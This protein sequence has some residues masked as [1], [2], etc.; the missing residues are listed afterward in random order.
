MRR[1]ILLI[2][3][4]AILAS[5]CGNQ[6]T[7]KKPVSF[8]YLHAEFQFG[9]TESLFGIE[10]AESE[11]LELLQ[12]L[13]HYLRGPVSETLR[14]PFPDKVQILS[15][16]MHDDVMQLIMNDRY[17]T[18]SG[19]SLSVANVCLFKTCASLTGIHELQIRTATLLI[20]GMDV[21]ILHEDDFITYD[22]HVTVPA[23]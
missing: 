20:D 8:Y 11:G 9:N 3:I 21:L 4:L 18:L 16:Q 17:A 13:N 10:N 5:G 6:V 15:L 12:I 7:L 23:S 1:T 22:H 14:S 2:T 19:V